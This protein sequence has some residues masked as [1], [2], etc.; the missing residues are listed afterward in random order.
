MKK[1][2]TQ[3]GNV[4]FGMSQCRLTAHRSVLWNY[5]NP[6]YFLQTSVLSV[7]CW[8][9]QNTC[10]RHSSSVLSSGFPPRP[11]S[12]AGRRQS[13]ECG[14]WLLKT[15]SSC[16]QNNG[17][18]THHVFCKLWINRHHLAQQYILQVQPLYAIGTLTGR[19]LGRA[20]VITIRGTRTQVILL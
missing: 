18:E 4:W 10:R 8:A 9:K 17:A 15:P 16:S 20:C 13:T 12:A 19:D 3:I 1:V 11:R 2:C 14:T 7:R 5:T 6:L